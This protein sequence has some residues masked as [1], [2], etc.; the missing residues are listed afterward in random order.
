MEFF[1]RKT[2]IEFMR[3]RRWWYAISCL[4]VV[5]SL[6]LVAFRGLN[7][8]I[9]FTGGVVVE[10]AFPEAADLDEIRTALA[11]AGHAEAS[12]QSFGTAQEVLVR[13]MPETGADVNQLG[14]N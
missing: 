7:F 13:L 12:V 1:K 10:L 3:R 6:L 4:L 2:S 14:M 11:A 9:D 8:G 5:G